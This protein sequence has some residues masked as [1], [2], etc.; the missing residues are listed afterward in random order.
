MIISSVLP[1]SEQIF[2]TVAGGSSPS[3]CSFAEMIK[4]N[5]S[6]SS[7]SD[8]GTDG[9]A[10]PIPGS[11]DDWLQAKIS[12]SSLPKTVG[13][14]GKK[15]DRL[16]S[17]LGD[18]Y[19]TAFSE[20]GIY[21]SHGLSASY[22]NGEFIVVGRLIQFYPNKPIPGIG[23]GNTDGLTQVGEGIGADIEQDPQP[24][25]FHYFR[26]TMLKMIDE[27]LKQ[28]FDKG[29]SDL[30]GDF[31]FNKAIW[32][33]SICKPDFQDA[34]DQEPSAALDKYRED[35]IYYMENA[36]FPVHGD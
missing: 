16:S 6:A 4:S 30:L 14:A 23:M 32:E 13:D 31:S 29:Q 1:A 25:D 3:G 8:L 35:I 10:L 2:S 17:F 20:A 24:M 36:M 33:L 12:S 34:Y 22:V 7:T 9:K 26:E 15:A 28:V 21:G 5:V 11:L 18:Y 19:S 27:C